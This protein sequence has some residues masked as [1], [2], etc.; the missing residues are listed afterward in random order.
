MSSGGTISINLLHSFEVR[1]GGVATKVP[2]AAQRLVAFV[3][4]KKRS[5]RRRYVAGSLWIDSSEN[6]A[7][8]NLRSALWRLQQTGLDVLDCDTTHI[9]LRDDVVVDLDESE[10]IAAALLRDHGVAE[11]PLDVCE[12]AWRGD[13]LPDWYDDWLVLEQERYRQLRIHA[14]EQ[15]CSHYANRG[16]FAK[17]IDV[18]LAAV[19]A[20]P[21]R[22][23][24]HRRVIEAHLA[25]DNL[26]EARRQYRWCENLLRSELDVAPSSGLT[27]LLTPAQ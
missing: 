20:E 12:R 9:G 22:E 24:A 2:P 7:G 8:A 15:L 10:R 23:S 5:L 4:I 14:L 21:L 27:A 13:L 16:L 18:G 17:A 25:E 19:E 26:H 1:V 3:A 11:E 6:R